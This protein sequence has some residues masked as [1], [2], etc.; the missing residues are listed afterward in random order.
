MANKQFKLE[1][2]ITYA[3]VFPENMDNGE[4]HVKKGGAYVCNFYYKNQEDVDA[5]I[6][7]GVPTEQLGWP[8][9]R[10]DADGPGIGVYTKLKRNH[11]GGFVNDAGVDIFGGPP[12]VYDWTDG[13]SAKMWSHDDDGA[14]GNGSEV[15]VVIDFWTTKNGKGLRLDQIA[16]VDAVEYATDEPISL[17]G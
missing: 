3:K 17:A 5:M 15:M 8:T 12:K 10:E 13:P 4:F 7:A 9:F 16:V 1:G 11:K 6:K 14:L 2:F